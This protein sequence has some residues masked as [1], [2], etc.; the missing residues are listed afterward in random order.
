MYDLYLVTG[1]TGYLGGVVVRRLAQSG[2]RIRVLAMEG[3]KLADALPDGVEKV[4][5]GVEDTQA[6]EHFFDCNCKNACVI[7]CAGIVS[8]ASHNDERL[9]SVN[10]GGTKS[11]T[12]MCVAR[13]AAKLI[14][15]SSVH[16]IPEKPHGEVMS[17]CAE[18]SPQSVAG[19]YAKTKAAATAYVLSAARRGL[20]VSV[21]HPSG[22]IGP[23]GSGAG[24]VTGT[25]ISYCSGKLNVGVTGGYDFVDVRDVAEGIISCCEKGRAGECYI[26]SN[27]YFSVREILETL[28]AL[29]KGRRILFYVPLPLVKLIAPLCERVS[30]RRKTPLFLTPYSVYTMGVNSLFSHEK[31][32]RELGYQPRD[33]SQTLSDMVRW[34]V[35]AG[36]IV[37]GTGRSSVRMRKRAA[38]R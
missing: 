21:V 34:L 7:H 28:R 33:M 36:K 23:Y 15:V 32:T 20:N 12:D 3:D 16:A 30:L 6:L 17:E 27:R 14:Y 31:A 2:A 13:G 4:Y 11:V 18:F 26:L 9:W 38:A 10:V 19:D 37:P 24:S 1:A 35:M 22:I 29:T 25:I 5:G 8:I